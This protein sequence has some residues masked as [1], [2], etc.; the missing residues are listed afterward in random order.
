MKRHR[1]AWLAL[2]SLILGALALPASGGAEG[3]RTA[4]ATDGKYI[5]VFRGSVGDPADDT[6]DMERSLSFKANLRYETAIK[7]FA[8]TLNDQQVARVRQDPDVAFVAP[9]RPVR[10]SV[11]LAPGDTAPSGIR[12]IGASAGGQVRGSSPVNV[13]VIDTGIDLN[14]TDL[15]S[16]SGTNC[17][18]PGTAAQDDNGHGTHVAGSIAARNNGSGVVGVA[19]GTKVFAVKVLNAQGSGTQSQV[20]CGIDWAAGTRTDGDPSNDIAVAN[21]SLGGTTSPLST[22]A[23]TT[24]PEHRA[25][26]N[27]TAQ[28]VHFVVAAGNSGY[29][30]DYASQPDAPAAYPQVLTVT[31]ASDSD[32]APGATGGAPTCRSGEADDRYASFSNYAATAA[33]QAHTI[34]APGTCITST[35]RGGGTSV[36][37]GT[38]MASPHMA[39]AVAL[40][41]GEGTAAGPCAGMTPAQVILKMRADADAHNAAN[42]AY[43]FTGDPLRPV[44]GRYFGYLPWAGGSGGGPP[45]EERATAAPSGV[46]IEP[47][48]GTLRSGNATRLAADDNLFYEVNSTTSG[49]RT[50]SWYGTFTSVPATLEN[51]RVTYRGKASRACSQTIS[52]WRWS[53]SSWVTLDTRSVGTTESAAADLAPTGSPSAYLSGGQ[54]RVRVRCAGSTGSFAPSFFSSGDLLQI[55]YG[56]G[57]TPPPPDSTPPTIDSVSPAGGATGVSTGTQVAVGFSE[58]MNLSQTEAAFSLVRAGD[59]APVAGSFAWSGNTL[60]FTPSAPLAAATDYRARVTTGAR[61]AAGNALAS[62]RV[63]TFTTAT[64]PPSS[65]TAFPSA[66]TIEPG[67]GS[68]R[69]GTASNLAADDNVFYEVNSTAFGTPVTSWYGSFASVPSTLSDLR[70]TY[71]GKVSSSCS[72]TI[73]IFRW[74]DSAWVTLDTRTASTGE[75][76]VG[77]LAPPGA[78]AAYVGGGQTRVRV[79]CTGSG[80]FGGAFFASGELLKIVYTAS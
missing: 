67:G 10:A 70:V 20:I 51:L 43:G 35:A 3:Q 28:G 74:S 37:S 30:F 5:V 29:D 15:N 47:G 76:E 69:G 16:A 79:R 66:V 34:A 75:M 64:A 7:G 6:R 57:G 54:L 58:P 68:L 50:T 38:S 72:Q 77:N 1:P 44:T 17:I 55:T 52:I 26:C 60:T 13:A 62:E 48:G 73:S 33:G 49:T 53:D 8:A 27:A 61:D 63:W 14:H 31:A 21:M 40:C 45:P 18:T 32:G 65:T 41:L 11:A 9:D 23:S 78:P 80:T 59:G 42:A 25:I 46:T 4:D 71:R 24:D 2:A 22:C 12:R 39:G 19:P 36:A 56:T